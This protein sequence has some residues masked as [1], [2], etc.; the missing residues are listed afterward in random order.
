LYTILWLILATSCEDLMNGG[1][2]PCEFR[3]M[4]DI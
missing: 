1:C 2:K 3:Y 4:Q